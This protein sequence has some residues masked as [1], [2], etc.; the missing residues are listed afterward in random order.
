VNGAT[1]QFLYLAFLVTVIGLALYALFSILAE[2][3]RVSR[4]L[5]RMATDQAHQT[6]NGGR[7]TPVTAN[8]RGAADS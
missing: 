2:V 8:Q 4:T 5:S 1:F 3:R 7:E 6:Q